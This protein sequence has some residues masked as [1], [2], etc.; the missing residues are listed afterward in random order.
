MVLWIVTKQ[1]GWSVISR[2]VLKVDFGETFSPV[3]KLATIWI[4]LAIIASSGQ[5]IN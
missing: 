3:F 1:D 2:S 4:I 5:H